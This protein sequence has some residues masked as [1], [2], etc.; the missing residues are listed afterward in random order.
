MQFKIDYRLFA[1]KQ[2]LFVIKIKSPCYKEKNTIDYSAKYKEMNYYSLS[3]YLGADVSVP[4]SEA[5]NWVYGVEIEHTLK[6]NDL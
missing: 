5:L 3:G 2:Y 4:V 6:K 1:I